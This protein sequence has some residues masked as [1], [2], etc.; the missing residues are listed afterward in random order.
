MLLA[1]Q[2]QQLQDKHTQ[3]THALHQQSKALEEAKGLSIA[4]QQQLVVMTQDCKHASS[5]LNQEQQAAEAAGSKALKVGC[6]VW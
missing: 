6:G 2:F 3:A 5:A 4:L 1:R